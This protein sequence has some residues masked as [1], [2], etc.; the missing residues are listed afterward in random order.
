MREISANKL[1]E[2][3]TDIELELDQLRQLEKGIQQVKKEIQDD[4]KR[5]GLFYE[6]LALK[7]HNLVV[8]N[9]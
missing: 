9:L 4:S 2:L 3:A 7:L 5:A 1:R 6:S 8:V